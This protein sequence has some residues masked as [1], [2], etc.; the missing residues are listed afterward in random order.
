M[1]TRRRTL[2]SRIPV[3]GVAILVVLAFGAIAA[4]AAQASQEWN[5]GGSSSMTAL[6]LTEEATAGTGS[7]LTIT[8]QLNGTKINVTCAE[9]SSGKVFR[10]GTGETTLNLSSCTVAEPEPGKCNVNPFTLKTKT[11]MVTI[12]GVNYEKFVPLTGTKL[13][14]LY[15]SGCAEAEDFP[16]KG[17]FAGKAEAG[18]KLLLE[19][20]VEISKAA[21]EAVGAKLTFGTT[22]TAAATAGTLKQS[23]NGAYKGTLWGPYKGPIW[24]SNAAGN[25]WQVEGLK[26][27]WNRLI[28][29]KGSVSFSGHM[30]PSANLKWSCG[31]S[32]S[33]LLVRGGKYENMVFKFSGCTVQEPVGCSVSPFQT[34]ELSGS[35]STAN[36]SFSIST[37]ITIT[38]C[39]IAET[40]PIG[41]LFYASGQPNGTQLSEQPATLSASAL[42]FGKEPFTLTGTMSSY[43][44]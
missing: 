9:S 20:P 11:E 40:Y 21:A 35:G 31:V 17:S 12:E 39:A 32:S 36:M 5:I 6:G 28:A 1:D 13:G 44:P 10:G 41:G 34:K 24:G 16:L 25:D 27:P 23:L 26:L 38:G 3:L 8:G 33:G 7:G 37:G 15:I 19:Q 14:D 42:T 4:S 30:F 2:R 18:G 29:G 43:L 22:G